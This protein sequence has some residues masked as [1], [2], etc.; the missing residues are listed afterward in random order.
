MPRRDD[1]DKCYHEGV[2]HEA[3]LNRGPH[4]FR[5]YIDFPPQ[6]ISGKYDSSMATQYTELALRLQ[7]DF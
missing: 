1:L 4:E 3:L 7:Q 2:V 6:Y 5:A